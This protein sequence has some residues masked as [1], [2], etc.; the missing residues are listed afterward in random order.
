M[1]MMSRDMMPPTPVAAPV[2]LHIGRVVVGLD[3]EGDRPAV[4]D[5][6]DAGVLAHAQEPSRASSPWCACRGAQVL[7]GGLV[8]A[9]LRPHHRVHGQLGVGG[10]A[11]QDLAD[12]RVL[13]VLEAELGERL[14]LVGRAGGMLD[15]RR[16]PGPAVRCGG[17]RVEGV[18][19]HRGIGCCRLRGQQE[20][21]VVAVPE[22]GLSRLGPHSLRSPGSCRRER[23]REDGDGHLV[24]AGASA[25]CPG[26]SGRTVPSASG[27]DV[28]SSRGPAGPSRSGCLRARSLR[29]EVGGGLAAVLPAQGDRSAHMTGTD[30]ERRHEVQHM[31]RRRH[32]RRRTSEPI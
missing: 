9:V 21:L 19:G 17:L 3:L 8:G 30:V 25:G 13:V 14:G 32:S 5:V 28:P 6:D 2:G 15:G 1:A 16:R 29:P 7:L 11:A 10:A 26:R 4:A 18:S 20:H 22:G 27:R 23:H 31:G 12:A 24:L